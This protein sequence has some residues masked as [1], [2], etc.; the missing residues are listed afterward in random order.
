MARACVQSVVGDEGLTYLFFVRPSWPAYWEPGANN[1]VLNSMWMRA[2]IWVFGLHQLT[3][4][5]PALVG[6]AIYI[7]AAY[8]LSRMISGDWKIR[9]PLFVCLVYNPF[10]FDFL[11]AARGYG[12]ATAFLLAAIAV[13]ASSFRAEPPPRVAMACAAASA[14]MGLSF[15]ANFSFAFADAAAMLL[16]LVWAVR[17]APREWRRITFASLAPGIA[18][19]GLLTCYTLAHWPKGQLYEGADSLRETFQT[20]SEASLYQVNAMLVN[21]LWISVL[22]ALKPF[23]IPAA[24]AIAALRWLWLLPDW[25]LVRKGW[26]VALGALAAGAVAVSLTAHWIAFRLF[27]LLMPRN[28]TA[29]FLAPLLTLAIGAAAATCSPSRIGEWLRRGAMGVLFVLGGY[30]LLCLRLTYFKEWSYIAEAKQ[31]YFAAAY[32]N[33]TRCVTRVS[34]SWYYDSALDFYRDYS[35]RESMSRFTNDHPHEPGQQLYVFNYVFD[36][37]ILNA[38]DARKLRLVYRG[39][40]TDI[41]IA[42]TPEIADSPPRTCDAAGGGS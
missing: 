29:L 14:M 24:L 3:V 16:I 38:L 10:V 28:R 4:R 2:F 19:A 31:A 7:A 34:A 15:T 36:R 22:N 35:G 30:F 26:Q 1:H 32:Y 33:H 27:G 39:E 13:A 11:V 17:V 41:A 5:G 8:A 12:L 40:W 37:D 21:P 6:A 20:A 25:S 9:V 18:V 42:V 23:L